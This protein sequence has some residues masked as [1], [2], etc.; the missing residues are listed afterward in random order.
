MANLLKKAFSKKA[1]AEVLYSVGLGRNSTGEGVSPAVQAQIDQ[2]VNRDY[3]VLNNI[4][5]VNTKVSTSKSLRAYTGASAAVY[6]IVSK[7]IQMSANI[8]FYEYKIVDQGAFKAYKQLTSGDTFTLES[9]QKAAILQKKAMQQVDANSEINRVLNRPN[10]QQSQFEFLEN[11]YGFLN[12][13]GEAD[14]FLRRLSAGANQGTVREMYTLPTNYM[15]AVPDGKFPVGIGGWVFSLYGELGLR[16][17]E[18]LQ[19]KYFNPIWDSNNCQL[20]GLSP[21]QAMAMVMQLDVAATEAEIASFKNGGPPL[22]IYNEDVDQELSATQA[23]EF[24]QRFYNE[25]SGTDQVNK[26]ML[27]AGKLGAIKTGISPVDMNIIESKKISFQQLAAA[28]KMPPDFYYN[29]GD[30]STFNNQDAYKKSAYTEGVIPDVI[31]V[32]DGFNK[33][34]VKD[35]S[36]TFIDADLS[37]IPVLQQ[38]MKDLTDWLDKSP[39][40][41]LN[42][43]RE[44]K[45]QDRM[46]DPNMDKI[47]VPSSW[48]LLDDLTQPD[49]GLGT[50]FGDPNANFL[51]QGQQ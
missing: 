41:T 32:R 5:P 11:V 18:V 35:G 14:I 25:T 49:I 7:K 36:K 2:Y 42:E 12:L 38:N 3:A 1:F 40:I 33:V 13:T 9:L 50:N 43:R 8:P 23:G 4:V 28:W 19:I 29:A 48:T 26:I 22:I 21:I 47:Y 17:E 10:S 16:P 15:Q 34:L 6:I 45:G 27:A 39:E 51:D 24:K 20:R 44:L 30:S 31:R 37:N 46:K